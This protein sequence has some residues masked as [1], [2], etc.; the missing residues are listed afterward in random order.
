MRLAIFSDIHGNPIALDAVLRDIEAR[1]GAD[2]FIIVGDFSAIGYDPVSPLE[3]VAGLPDLLVVRGNTDRYTVTGDLPSP[4]VEETRA[5]PDLAPQLKHIAESF[6]WTRGFVTASGWYD[7]LAILP[8]EQRLVLPDGTRLLVVHASPN[9]DDGPGMQPD[10]SDAALS[11]LFAGCEADLVV[12]GHIHVPQ[13][14]TVSGMRIVD[15][16]SVSNPTT[17]DPRAHYVLIEASADGYRL[18]SHRVAYDFGAVIDSIQRARHPAQSFLL[19]F[20]TPFV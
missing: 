1:G 2:R 13:D 16:A 6:A 19:H 11:D 4:T 9:R 8:T 7:W 10:L 14:R 17:S 5:N 18:T 12:V 15:V 3:M 20:F